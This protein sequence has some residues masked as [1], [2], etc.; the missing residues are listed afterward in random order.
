MKTFS[1]RACMTDG[2]AVRGTI[3]ADSAP[4]AVRM[5]AAEGKTVLRIR[6]RRDFRLPDFL[7][8]RGSISAE[9][10]IAFLHELAAVLEAGLPVHEA[11]AHLRAGVS[12]HSFYGR[13]VAALHAEVSRGMPLSQTMEL[14]PAEFPE[15]LVGMV[16]AG[17]ESGSLATVLREAAVAL[18]EAHVLRESLRSALAYPIF[19]LGATALS[20]LIMTVFVL[21]V[22]AALLRDLG[23][24][25]P[26]PTRI[27]LGLS[28]VVLAQPYL[29]V[30]I[31]AAVCLAAVLLLR[32][33]SLRRY[34]DAVLLR[35]PVLGMFVKLSEWQMILR[36]LA[37]L[38]RSGIRLDRAVGLARMVTE[39][40]ALGARLLR[41]E[42]NLVEGRTLAQAM[43]GDLYMPI[44]LR[45]MLAAG[46]EAGD[47]ER[48]LQYGA[49]YCRR[50]AHAYAARMEALAEPV[51]IVIIAALIFF[52]VL[53]VLLPIFDT[54]DALM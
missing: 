20:V 42:Q 45:G 13:L 1:Y 6:E 52:V 30:A 51:M 43:A 4:A 34:G 23:A 7:R 15:S 31:I 33:P 22:F 12:E 3:A 19:L 41:V 18:T 29:V 26:L 9:E 46:E 25:L 48:L 37:I 49:D 16:R 39:N 5:L 54:M 21:P 44:L 11:L 14:R 27:L 28:D 36:T 10:R 17:E 47:L 38:L 2:S 40:R 35:V 50:R 24:Q 32:I 8:L 53:S